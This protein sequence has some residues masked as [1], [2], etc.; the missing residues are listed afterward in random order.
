MTRADIKEYLDSLCTRYNCG[1]F[2]AEDPISVPHRYERPED[3]EIAG[4]LAATIAWGRRPLIVRNALRM[5]ELMDDAPYQFVS[6]SGF[7]DWEALLPFVHRTFNGTDFIYFIRALQHIYRAHGGLGGFF[8]SSYAVHR[9]LRPVLS[10]FRR[11]FFTQELAPEA[12]TMRHLSSIDK[13]AACKRLCMYLKWMVRQDRSGVDF[14]LWADGIPASALYL[15]LDVHTANV[16]RELGLLGRR[17]NDWRAVEE[18]MAVLREFDADD[19]VRY[20]YALFSAGIHKDLPG[21][22]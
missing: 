17:Q 11:L 3:I 13:G 14:G 9:D 16:S 4:F 6:Q 1:A 7:A 19:P 22:R 2:I 5:M 8:R 15:P 12:R 10:D 18:V 21:P 20:D